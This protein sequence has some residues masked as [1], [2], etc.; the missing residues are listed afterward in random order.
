MHYSTCFMEIIFTVDEFSWA[1][2][3]KSMI[4]QSLAMLDKV[5]HVGSL[6]R[7]GLSAS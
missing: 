6:I 2:Y 3:G 4:L 7:I 5:G 1:A